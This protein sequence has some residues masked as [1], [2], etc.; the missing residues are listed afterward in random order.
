MQTLTLNFGIQ[1]PLETSTFYLPK[2]STADRESKMKDRQKTQK[3]KL[4]MVQT[5]LN[6]KKRGCHNGPQALP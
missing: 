3:A 5:H 4:K 6:N 2:G 1:E